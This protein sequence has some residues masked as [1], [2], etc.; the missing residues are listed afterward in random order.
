MRI[1]V[2][3]INP[4]LA[5]NASSMDFTQLYQ[6]IGMNTGNLMFT[7]AMYRQL[8]AN[9]EQIGFSFS[10]EKVNEDFDAIVI[11]A[12]NWLNQKDNWDWLSDLLEQVHIPAVTIGIG[13]Q[14][15]TTDLGAIRI[16]QSCDRFIRLLS[17]KAPFISTRG[18]LTTRFLQSIGVMNVVT[19][20]CPSIYMPLVD[21]DPVAASGSS[22]VIQSTRYYFSSEAARVR[23][24]N[25]LLFEAAGG[26]RYDM[27][28]QSEPEEM[29]YLLKPDSDIGSDV[30]RLIGLAKLYGLEDLGELKSYLDA[31]GR[32]FLDLDKWSAYLKSKQR[33]LGTRLHG[34]ILALNSGVPAMLLAHDS[35]TSEMIDFAGIPTASPDD[36]DGD[37]SQARL[38]RMFSDIDVDGYKA[39]RASNFQIYRQFM[40]ANG[41]P[42]RDGLLAS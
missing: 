14:A 10:P 7:T 8:N 1:G 19:T 16:S 35:R 4:A 33:V 15:D 24:L 38:D 6:A 36:F 27:I 13:L 32:T 17:A 42:L 18:F 40:Q 23:G 20:G 22:T 39:R 28:Y 11:P 21:S 37:F 29:E 26:F 5:N 25:N 41:L 9:V 12:A 3:S 30:A 34:A 2:I 31:H